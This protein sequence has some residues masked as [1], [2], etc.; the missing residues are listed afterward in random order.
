MS[1]ADDDRAGRASPTFRGFNP[2]SNP[3]VDELKARTDELIAL[4]QREGK[5]ARRVALAA[6]GYEEACMWAVKSLFGEAG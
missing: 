5:D 6:T 4:V 2:T 3:V 1:L